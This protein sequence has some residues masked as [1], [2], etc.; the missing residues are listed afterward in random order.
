M[1]N[2]T[3]DRRRLIFGAA[4]ALSGWSW[5]SLASPQPVRLLK[6]LTP[7]KS[8]SVGVYLLDQASDLDAFESWL[9][10]TVSH[11]AVFVGQANWLDFSAEWLVDMWRDRVAKLHWSIPLIVEGAT[12]SEA[13]SGAYN[14][15]YTQIAREIAVWPGDDP[16]YIRIGWEF[17]YS[18]M[19]WAAGGREADFKL[20]YRN[21]VNCFRKVSSR[22]RF[23]WCPNIGNGRAANQ[24]MAPQL[25]YPRDR[26]V[27]VIGLD[28][29]YFKEWNSADSAN[30]F[31]SLRDRAYGLR[32]HANFARAC[33]KPIAFSE[34]GVNS[35][36]KEEFIYLFNQWMESNGALWHNYWNRNS[37][38]ECRLSDGQYPR[39]GKGY[40]LTYGANQLAREKRRRLEAG[41]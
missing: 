29:Y 5:A 7:Q 14:R 21:M 35:D 9:G 36:N 27:D 3:I 15:R 13:A 39:T 34:W 4:A 33:R 10:K 17:N 25:A 41:I 6:T 12:L 20:A 16:M 37:A 31:A 8:P 18:G 19:L 28:V 2:D 40:L 26:F 1:T 11:V 38:I 22:F 32:W 24:I 23:E 30:A